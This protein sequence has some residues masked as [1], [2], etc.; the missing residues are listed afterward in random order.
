MQLTYHDRA[1]LYRPFSTYT[2]VSSLVGFKIAVNVIS[3]V[4]WY[5][6]PCTYPLERTCKGLSV[7]DAWLV[8]SWQRHPCWMFS[9]L[10]SGLFFVSLLHHEPR[11]VW[12]WGSHA[13][14]RNQHGDAHFTLGDT[15]R[16]TPNQGP[17][18]LAG[19]NK[20]EPTPFIKGSCQ[21]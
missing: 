17:F 13:L 2:S 5:N 7:S 19:A 20:T 11:V 1:C 9:D 6:G 8:V 15:H 10:Q 21:R 14:R 16:N 12:A 3:A 4:G 18:E